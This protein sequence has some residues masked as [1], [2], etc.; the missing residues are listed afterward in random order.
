MI[1]FLSLFNQKSG[2]NKVIIFLHI[3]RTG[4]SSLEAYIGENYFKYQV[5]SGDNLK[6]L[7]SIEID[8]RKKIKIVIGHFNFGIHQH[9]PQP[10]TYIT[11]FRNPVD[12]IIS[13]FFYAKKNKHHKF[14]KKIIEESLHLKDFL[15]TFPSSRQLFNSQLQ[16]VTG[17]SSPSED[18]LI[19]AKASVE[20][21]FLF[22]GL[23]E[24]YNE[25]INKI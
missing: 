20:K 24:R 3:P 17:I 7:D 14:H 16:H 25:G 11:F 23:T 10:S 5:L 12:R 13:L 22:V 15:F 6:K 18:T 2:D 9:F 8:K 21:K 1:N 4:G 19:Q